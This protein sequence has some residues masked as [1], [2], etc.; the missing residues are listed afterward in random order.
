[1][2]LEKQLSH[3]YNF[4]SKFNIKNNKLMNSNFNICST[5]ITKTI[6]NSSHKFNK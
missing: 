6:F 3:N 5:F 2:K 1:M 4:K